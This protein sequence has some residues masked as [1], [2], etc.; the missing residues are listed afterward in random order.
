MNSNRRCIFIMIMLLAAMGVNAQNLVAYHVMGKVTY[1]TSSGNKAVELNTR[2]TASTIVNI[3]YGGKLELLDEQGKKRI[4]ISQVGKGTI[5]QLSSYN[6]NSI[7]VLTDKYVAYVKK[8][9]TNKG[10]VSNKRYTDFAVVTRKQD[11]INT[12]TTTAKKESPFA[13]RFNKFKKDTENKFRSFREECNDRYISFVREAWEKCGKEPPVLLPSEPRLAP[14][15]FDALKR[16]QP[17][18]SRKLETKQILKGNKTNTKINQPQPIE[19]I[20]EVETPLADR[21]FA[22]MP[23]IFFGNEFSVRLDETKRI[24]L[25]KIEP[26]KIAQALTHFSGQEYDNLLFDCLKLRKEHKLCDWAYLEMLKSI[27]DQ[28][29]G[30]GTNEA[31]LLMGYLYYQSGYKMRFAYDDYDNLAL[32]VATDYMLYGHP[33]FMVDNTRFYP[34]QEVPE[35]LNICK[36]AFPKEQQLSLN[37]NESMLLENAET[38][39]RTIASADYPDFKFTAPINRSLIEFFETYP[40]ASIDGSPLNRWLLHANAPLDQNLKA[41]IYP[42]LKSQIEN[43][44]EYEAVSRLLNIVQT[45]LKYGYDEDLWGGDRTFFAEESIYYPYCDCEDR[46]I[47]FTRLVRDLLGLE[48]ILI[49]YPGHLASAVHFNEDVAGSYYT[50][51]GK[52]YVVC[53]GTYLHAPIGKEMED[54]AAKGAT[55]IP[56]K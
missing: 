44:S 22:E 43:L 42:Q 29:C 8:Q 46:S 7:S 26:E 6:G 17:I 37:I 41:A 21:E 33:S 3:P 38:E 35:T 2:L 31:V 14:V 45:G 19:E 20:K 27:T 9:L 39:S 54:M 13:A 12:A 34:V 48:C 11:S 36:A 23:F 55:L 15:V 49:Y 53:D 18:D 40:A 51:E 56:L 24:N 16:S 25:G 5:Q 28:F 32:L 4:T 47:L 30:S 10:L 52:N 1:S 50:Y